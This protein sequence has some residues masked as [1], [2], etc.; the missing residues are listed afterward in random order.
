MLPFPHTNDDVSSEKEA[1]KN[2]LLVIGSQY[3][4]PGRPLMQSHASPV[5]LLHVPKLRHVSHDQKKASSH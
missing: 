5:N 2:N 4:F 3:S 1:K